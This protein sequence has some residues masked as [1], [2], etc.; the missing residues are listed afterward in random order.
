MYSRLFGFFLAVFLCSMFPLLATAQPGWRDLTAR[1]TYTILDENQKEISFKLNRDYAV[2][3]DSTLYKS[4]NIPQDSLLPAQNNSPAFDYQIRIN[5]FSIALR[6]KKLEEK[7]LEIKI[8]RENDT[9]FISQASK[10]TLQFKPGHYYFPRWTENFFENLPRMA[11]RKKILNIDQ[12][13]FIVPKPLYDSLRANERKYTT[14]ADSLIVNNFMKGH[15]RFTRKALPILFDQSILQ[16]DDVTSNRNEEPYFQTKNDDYLGIINLSYHKFNTTVY[17]GTIVR[18]N[19]RDFKM[20]IWSPTENLLCSS[21]AALYKDAFNGIYYNNSLTRKSCCEPEHYDFDASQQFYQSKNEGKTW[22]KEEKLD[23][24]YKKLKFRELKFL[25]KKHAII[26]VLNEIKVKDKMYNLQQGTYYLLRDLH[27]TDSLKTPENIHYNGNHNHFQYELKNDTIFLGTWMHH[28]YP[29][30]GKTY[31]KPFI[32]KVGNKW[33]FNVAEKIFFR[34]EPEVANSTIR[35]K[36][37]DIV[38]G[39]EILFPDK[40]RMVFNEDLSKLHLKQTILENG[41]NIFLIGL[42]L[43]C[44]ISYDGGDFWYAYPLPLE[45]ESLYEF[46]GINNQDEISHLKNSWKDGK[47]QFE[48]V[49]S[50]FFRSQRMNTARNNL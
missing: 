25:D 22:E 34:H 45:K 26:F 10:L 6:Q 27:I 18:F 42:K 11:Q 5:D 24:L 20:S 44:L 36:N 46:I 7:N 38:N 41:E 8:I 2:L 1:Y 9:M 12:R 23:Q 16:Y 28:E 50:Q 30:V 17:R 15:F 19:K 49:I 48:K 3:I 21:T 13:N 35:Y 14:E 4:P 33:K 29:E 32:K 31:F 39:N 47:F 40:E 37:F 43:G